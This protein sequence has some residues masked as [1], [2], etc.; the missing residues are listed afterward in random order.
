VNRQQTTTLAFAAIGAT[1]LAFSLRLEPGSDLFVVSTLTLA[2]VWAVGAFAAGPLH[3]GRLGPQLGAFAE[4]R[5]PIVTSLGVGALLA[6]VFVL[7]A[8]VVRE[9]EPL[10]VAVTEVVQYAD[11][12]AGPLILL[13][14]VLNGL[15]EEIFFRGA[16]YDAVPRRKVLATTVLY[17]VATALTGNVMLAFAAIVIGAVTGWQR[18]FT[19]GILAPMLT[20]ITWSVSML[21]ALPA[22]FPA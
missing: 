2:A 13:V 8:L 14:T 7:G 4:G 18:H 11:Q 20:H 22:L 12:G 5:R 15:A 21:Y 10:R 17:V 9:I 1:V 3:L 6:G 16:V 19:G